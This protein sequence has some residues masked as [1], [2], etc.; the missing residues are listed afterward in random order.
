MPVSR[1]DVIRSLT[2]E[3][4]AEL[5]LHWDVGDEKLH[6]C[7]NRPECIAMDGNIEV[8]ACRACLLAWLKEKAGKC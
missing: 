3:E 5:I 6:F 7:K 1:G 8:E 4:L 2:D